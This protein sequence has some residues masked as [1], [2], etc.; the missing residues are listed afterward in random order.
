MMPTTMDMA[1]AALRERGSS[2]VAVLAGAVGGAG[3]GVFW[4]V[5]PAFAGAGLFLA[6]GSPSP[7]WI[8]G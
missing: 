8:D 1:C 3:I 6:V 5:A 2:L 4:S 7:P